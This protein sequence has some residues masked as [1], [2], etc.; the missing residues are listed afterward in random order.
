M[1]PLMHMKP[2]R[3]TT[4]T[5]SKRSAR[6]CSAI[7]LL[8][9]LLLCTAIAHAEPLTCVSN[10]LDHPCAASTSVTATGESCDTETHQCMTLNIQAH[11]GEGPLFKQGVGC[12][13]KD[14]TDYAT[15]CGYFMYHSAIGYFAMN[16][17]CS[18]CDTNDCNV[19]ENINKTNLLSCNEDVDMDNGFDEGL[20]SCKET[21]LTTL[22]FPCFKDMNHW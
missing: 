5:M 13:R 17:T 20:V 18:Y 4:T 1:I 3:W 8:L 9:L 2:R 22:G 10:D 12:V 6:Q 16:V 15:A 14:F 7:E 21:T 11:G 19:C